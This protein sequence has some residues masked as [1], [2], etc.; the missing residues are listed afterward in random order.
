MNACGETGRIMLNVHLAVGTDVERV[1]IC[2]VPPLVCK[3][4][5]DH[6]DF[7]SL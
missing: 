2:S 7:A 4:D 3:P 1:L 6:I 5:Q